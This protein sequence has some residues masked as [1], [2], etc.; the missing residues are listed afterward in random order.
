MIIIYRCHQYQIYLLFE[1]YDISTYEF[2]DSYTYLCYGY[3]QL[4]VSKSEYIPK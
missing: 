2:I 3:M 4:C 1:D